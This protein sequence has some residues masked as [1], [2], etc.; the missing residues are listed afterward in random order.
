MQGAFQRV[1]VRLNAKET[2]HP[3]KMVRKVGGPRDLVSNQQYELEN[4]SLI[5]GRPCAD[6]VQRTQESHTAFLVCTEVTRFQESLRGDMGVEMVPKQEPCDN[7][8][9]ELQ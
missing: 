8:F 3:F 1:R 6:A 9:N 5:P 4:A 2:T 7:I